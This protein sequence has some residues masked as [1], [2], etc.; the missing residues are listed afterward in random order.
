[1]IKKFYELLDNTKFSKSEKK[2]AERLKK[3]LPDMAFLTGQEFAEVCNVNSSTITRFAQKLGY[4]GYPELKRELQKIYKKSFTPLEI[5]QNFIQ[6]KNDKKSIINLSYQQDLKNIQTAMAQLNEDNL[7]KIA[8]VI[9]EAK[10]LYI[11][12]IGASETLVDVFYYYFD[13]INRP[14]VALKGFGISKKFEIADL[15]TGDVV[16]AISFQRILKEVYDIVLMAK[17][18]NLTTIAITDSDFNSLA[19]KCDYSLIAPVVP[20]TFSLSI[21]APLVVINILLNTIS[22]LYPQKI[23][24]N[25]KRIQEGWNNLPIFADY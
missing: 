17:K 15:E 12:A 14:Y 22:T 21:A 24:K 11:V 7:I 13:A 18:K 10:K 23:Q 9:Y 5:F 8:K 25:L 4:S 16:M 1:M 2:I 6:N 3:N 20:L 19:T